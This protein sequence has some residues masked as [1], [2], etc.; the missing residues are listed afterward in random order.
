MPGMRIRS[1]LELLSFF[2]SSLNP[3]AQQLDAMPGLMLEAGVT[4]AHLDDFVRQV[5][6]CH[7]RDS[8]QSDD[9]AAVADFFHPLVEE[10]SAVDQFAALIGPTGD[11]VFFF[12]DSD[13]ERAD[14]LARVAHALCSIAFRRPIIAS[15]RVR[16]CSLRLSKEVFSAASVSCR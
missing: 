14:R 13:A 7:Y 12:Q 10:L 15:T 4:G 11:D 3:F 1:Q 16:T 8:V 5:Q 9:L 6:R 2:Q